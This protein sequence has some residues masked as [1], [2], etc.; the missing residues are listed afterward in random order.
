MIPSK[1][2]EL[3][4]RLQGQL[5]KRAGAEVT[6][7]YVDLPQAGARVHLL[8]AGT[9]DP[10][11]I[12]HG[13][14]GVGAEHIPLL[15]HLSRRFRVVLPDRPGH[16]LSG[17]F[18]YRRDLTQANVEF[19]AALLD[20]LGIE[21]AAIVGNSYGGLMAVQFAIAHP[22]RVSRLVLL[23]FFPGIDRKLPALMRVTVVP[24]LGSLLGRIFGRPTVN[25]TRKFFSKLLVAHIERMPDELVELEALH[26]RR[27]G[28]SIAGLFREGF[29]V[30]GFRPRYLVG[31]DL[32][33]LAVPTFWLWGERDAFM[34]LDSARATAA[35]I[36]GARFSVIPDAGHLPTTDQPAETAR[37]L[38]HALART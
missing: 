2:E 1:Y 22:E 20:E 11:V 35:R 17:D 32:P 18:D 3:Y 9:G 36:P 31:A 30:R 4:E 12:L 27:H 37:Q 6:S 38:E 10:V 14:A 19:V 23:G 21:R 25:N 8:E 13:G 26:S 34:P 24:V 29:T 16:G 28:R 15:A 5:L 7:R 33:K